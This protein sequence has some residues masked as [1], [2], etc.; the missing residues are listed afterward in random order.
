L[1]LLCC[2]VVNFIFYLVIF[3]YAATNKIIIFLL[4]SYS[5]RLNSSF[6]YLRLIFITIVLTIRGFAFIYTSWY[7]GKN[8]TFSIL[9]LLFV[10]RMLLLIIFTNLWVFI[11]GWDFLGV[12]SYVLVIN[13]QNQNSNNAGM[14]TILSNRVGDSFMIMRV[15]LIMVTGSWDSVIKTNHRFFLLLILLMLTRITK[16]AQIPFCAWLPAAMAAPTPVSALV[17][18]STL[19][20]AGVYL[21]IR[22]NQNNPSYFLLLTGI[23][24][25]LLAGINACNGFDFKKLIALSTL[26]QL[27]LMFISLGLGNYKLALYHLVSHGLVKALLFLSAGV[28]IHQTKSNQDLRVITGILQTLP[29]TSISVIFTRLVLSGLPFM[30]CFFSKEIIINQNFIR[31]LWIM[32]NIYVAARLTINYRLRLINSILKT[33]SYWNR[34]NFT[35]KNPNTLLPLIGLLPFSILWG[36]SRFW[37]SIP[38]LNSYIQHNI[39]LTLI[40]WLLII[41]SVY[42]GFSFST[43]KIWGDSIPNRLFTNLLFLP[44]LRSNFLN[45][46]SR[47]GFKL[48][49]NIETAWSESLG[50]QGSYNTVTTIMLNSRLYFITTYLISIVIVVMLLICFFSL[51]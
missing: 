19:V 23:F 17:H 48:S 42:V 24:T 12:V 36:A 44:L 15:S 31:R 33:P 40:T 5:D 16:R 32:L 22:Y 3:K 10:A 1:F 11:W 50:A 29:I 18:S 49:K 25:T 2:L 39:V 30:T 20:T 41:F 6:D 46:V 9:V 47:I 21:V 37:V 35:E 28:I 45:S 14:I 38:I 13:Y 34:N 43:N 4:T 27:G 8:S 26:R 7:V 51:Y